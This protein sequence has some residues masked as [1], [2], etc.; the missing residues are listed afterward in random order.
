MDIAIDKSYQTF[1]KFSRYQQFPIYY[2]VLD[3]KYF[4]GATTWLS[5]KTSYI[6]HKVEI[7]D[8]LDSLAYQYYGNP[9][10]YWIIA[11]FNRIHDP[12]KKLETGTNIKI[13]SFSEIEFE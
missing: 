3:D 6:I 13:P 7:P 10:F 9:T 12:F 11:D 2:N 1:N 5:D 4:G 8:T